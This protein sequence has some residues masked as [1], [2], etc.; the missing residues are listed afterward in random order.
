[1]SLDEDKSWFKYA[2]GTPSPAADVFPNAI[3]DAGQVVEG[4]E[5]GAFITGF[6]V[7]RRI[8]ARWGKWKHGPLWASMLPD[9]LDD[10]SSMSRPMLS[11]LDPMV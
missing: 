10:P 3:D 4:S 7:A 6:N 5:G 1:M 11:S 9:R 2:S 8:L